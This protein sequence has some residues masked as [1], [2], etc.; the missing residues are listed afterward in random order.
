MKDY[1]KINQVVYDRFAEDFEQST[2]DYLQEHLLNDAELF[3]KNLSGK[4]ILDIGSGPGRDSL[5]FKQQDL[6]PVCIDLSPEMIRRCKEKG[7]D[8]YV[9][10]I[11]QLN[12]KE[13]SFDGAW[14]YTS[15]LH[16]PKTKLPGILKEISRI[17]TDEGMFYLGMKE[18]SFEGF[19]EGRYPGYEYF[20]TKF[21]GKELK[22][23][24]SSEFEVIHFSKVIT[25]AAYLNYLCKVKKK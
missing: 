4:R 23:I 1:K 5:Y 19:K 18:G 7:L 12:F 25:G 16:L 9:M 21:T 6:Q 22:E 14:A 17:L 24:L 20:F 10:D 13:S 2:K 15:L 8:A 11:E 3:I